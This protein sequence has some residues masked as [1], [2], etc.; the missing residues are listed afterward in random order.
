[1]TSASVSSDP[2]QDSAISLF[3]LWHVLLAE[4]RLLLASGTLF[5][6]AAVALALT[7]TPVYRAESIVAP[8]EAD[9]REGSASALISQLGGV[10]GLAGINLGSL[11]SSA[12][13]GRIIIQSR[14]LLEEFIRRNDLIPVLLGDAQTDRPPTLWR[15]VEEFKKIYDAEEDPETGLITVRVEWTDPRLAAQWTNSLVKLSN[16]LLRQRDLTDAQRNIKYLNEQLALTN[17]VGL[18]QV[19]YNLIEGEMKTLMLANAREEYALAVVDQA[20]V[21]E[22]R[23][24]P[25]RTQMT[26]LGALLGGIVGVFAVAI[27]RTVRIQRAQH[28]ALMAKSR[29][30]DRKETQT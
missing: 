21:P 4:W 11:T 9:R 28:E 14:S 10:A 15:A 6:A 19:I 29:S 7:M 1:M 27:R 30:A 17:V 25:K 13:K 24:R 5:T 26:V 22:M 2:Q 23:S 16:E 8:V 18:Q 3:H 20:V 12:N